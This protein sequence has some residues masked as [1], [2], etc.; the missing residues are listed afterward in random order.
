VSRQL[1]LVHRVCGHARSAVP[2][3]RR[4]VIEGTRD[5]LRAD[6]DSAWRVRT[7]RNIAAAVKLAASDPCPTCTSDP[8]A[9]A[10]TPGDR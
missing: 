4:A 2:V 3:E 6:G 9:T 8:S 1:V 10:S 7:V 5:Q